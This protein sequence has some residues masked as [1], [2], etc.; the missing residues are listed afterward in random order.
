MRQEFALTTTVANPMALRV[1]QLRPCKISKGSMSSERDLFCDE[2]R[3][4][5]TV[6]L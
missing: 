2:I 3:I 4:S 1:N 6:H 5:R